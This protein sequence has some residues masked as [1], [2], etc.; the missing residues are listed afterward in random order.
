MIICAKDN[1]LASGTVTKKGTEAK[2]KCQLPCTS[3]KLWK[4]LEGGWAL[5]TLHRRS[6][7]KRLKM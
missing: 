7:D 4:G 2:E 3:R 5:L 6:E 1:C